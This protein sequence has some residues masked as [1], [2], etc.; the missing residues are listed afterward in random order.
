MGE[1]N[2]RLRLG[3]TAGD[4]NGVGPEIIFFCYQTNEI[5]N[6]HT[7]VLYLNHYHF[8]ELIKLHQF[9]ME[10]IHFIE[11]AKEAKDGKLNVCR[12]NDKKFEI[13]IGKSSKETGN[14]AIAAL[15]QS[16]KDVMDGYIQNIVTAPIDK[17]SV[18]NTDFDFRGH[19]EFFA[20]KFEIETHMML[21]VSDEM[22][23][24]MVT[25]HIP[26]NQI[27]ESIN[28]DLI[29]SKA[30]ML[31]QSLEEDFLIK[32][33]KIAVLGLNPHSGDNG[34]IGKEEQEVLIPVIDQLQNDMHIFGPYGS[35]G[36]FGSRNYKNF[37]GIL[38]MY[39]DQ[40]L[41]PFKLASFE[42]GVNYTAGLPIV[43][44]SPDHGVAFD[45]AGKKKADAGSF[46]HAVFLANTIHHNRL[47]Y[48]E[49][50]KNPLQK[51]DLKSEKFNLGLPR[52]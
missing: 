45:L 4:L 46:I 15:K 3:I 37:D 10:N 49:S 41:I 20:K 1:I 51:S 47:N 22:K 36:F 7:P 9:E 8:K 35:D 19:T 27:S 33:P 44:T 23:I 5:F 31:K 29:I 48:F 21:M 39:H 50:A 25:T 32:N 17:Y 14:F 26:V 6:H 18:Q 2:K 38:A 40:A 13:E 11:H 28:A 30:Q 34:L 52:I 12:V 43:R 42:T 24:G 16:I